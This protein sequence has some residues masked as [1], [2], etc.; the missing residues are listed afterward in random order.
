MV[1]GDN[2]ALSAALA[3]ETVAAAVAVVVAVAED[4]ADGDGDRIGVVK[5]R[6]NIARSVIEERSPADGHSFTPV[7]LR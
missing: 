6:A 7:K 4:D 5:C 3:A 2:K 1:L